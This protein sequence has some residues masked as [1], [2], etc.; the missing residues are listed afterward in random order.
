M[1]VKIHFNWFDKGFFLQ[2]TSKYLFLI[3]DKGNLDLDKLVFFGLL[4]LPLYLE[5]STW[6]YEE[7]WGLLTDFSCFTHRGGYI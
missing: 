1:T 7:N 6:Q 4:S 5:T 2:Q 3:S